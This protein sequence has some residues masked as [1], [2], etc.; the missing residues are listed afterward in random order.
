MEV[1]PVIQARK[2]G[3]PLKTDL[4]EEE[5]K[6]RIP[7]RWM[8]CPAAKIALGALAVVTL[9]G[10]EPIAA[11]GL[12]TYTTPTET[13]MSAMPMLNVAPLFEHGN[14]QGAFG[15]VMVAPPAFLSEDEALTVI[16]DAALEYGLK[17]TREDVPVFGGVLQPVTDMY[18]SGDETRDTFVRF[19]PDFTEAEHG[20]SIEFVSTNDVESWNKGEETISVGHYDTKG[21]AAQLSEAFESAIPEPFGSYNA[22][23]LYDP[24][25]RCKP[26]DFSGEEE[27]SQEEREAAWNEAEAKARETAEEQLAAQAKDFFEWLKAQGVI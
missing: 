21:A 24:C 5:L 15:C 25:E 7:M 10:C 16:N 1:K 22:G 6:K 11:G 12:M 18:G 14:G 2:P 9:A 8:Q 3:Y 13:S 19:T 27:Y 20:I 4:K 23:V 17:F 26:E